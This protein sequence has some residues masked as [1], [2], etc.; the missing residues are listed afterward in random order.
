MKTTPYFMARQMARNRELQKHKESMQTMGST[1]E[2]TQICSKQSVQLQE[3]PRASMASTSSSFNS[4]S[5]METDVCSRSERT[6]SDSGDSV[7]TLYLDD[8]VKKSQRVVKEPAVGLATVGSP[9]ATAQQMVKTQGSTLVG[10]VVVPPS[11]AIHAALTASNE[12]NI[13]L[14]QLGH[15]LQQ[16]GAIGPM[17]EDQALAQR[18]VDAMPQF[19]ED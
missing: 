13:S 18:L 17:N 11:V 15:T 7:M 12:A 9:P 1:E 5:S 14:V 16:L 4:E 6:D 2:A 3:L 10:I 8:M 19:Y